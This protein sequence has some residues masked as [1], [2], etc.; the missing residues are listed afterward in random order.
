MPSRRKR[1]GKT[2][3]VKVKGFLIQEHGGELRGTEKSWG[4]KIPI[5]FLTRA[6]AE[7]YSYLGRVVA[8]TITVMVDK[9]DR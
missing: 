8:A 4:T 5:P 7:K 3:G 9:E 6:G 1:P 2:I